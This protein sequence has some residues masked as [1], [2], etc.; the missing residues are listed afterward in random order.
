MS[1]FIRRSVTIGLAVLLAT[2]LMAGAALAQTSPVEGCTT[3]SYPIPPGG[4]TEVGGEATTPPAEQPETE[5]G[6]GTTVTPPRPQTPGQ[7][8]TQV[9]GTSTTPSTVFAQQGLAATGIDAGV[10]ALLAVIALLGGAGLILLGRK[11]A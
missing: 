3:D 1:K 9:L 10:M 6:G 8:Q 2:F 4:C 5:V 7:P 11:R